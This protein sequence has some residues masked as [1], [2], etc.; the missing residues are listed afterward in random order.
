MI[1]EITRDM[2][3]LSSIR[4]PGWV[5]LALL[6]AVVAV[7]FWFDGYGYLDRA[8]PSLCAVAVLGFAIILKWNL[9]RHVWFWVT[10]G[11]LAALHASL[12]A[13]IGGTGV[14]IPG[15]ILAVVNSVDLVLVLSVLALVR[16]LVGEASR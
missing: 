10:I 2:K 3:S 13:W 11:T 4:L 16:R 6:P 12:I 8:L 7:Y 15:P 14:W 5:P 1:D 9:R